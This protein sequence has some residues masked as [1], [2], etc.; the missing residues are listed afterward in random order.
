MDSKQYIFLDN[1][2]WVLTILVIVFHSSITAI[3]AEMNQIAWNLPNVAK[4]MQWQYQILDSFMSTYSSFFMCVF[5]FISAY[6]VSLSLARKGAAHFILDKLKRLGIPIL[7]T[8]FILFPILISIVFHFMPYNTTAL[9]I[10]H[11]SY[12]STLKHFLS[13]LL[14]TDNIDLGV[15]WFTWMLIV[16]STFFALSKKLYSASK[17]KAGDKRIPAIWLYLLS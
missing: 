1:L 17:L 15:T 7:M 13:P 14:R 4:S 11:P 5:F 12:M 9:G 3:S 10:T 6:F 8:L 16:F 2:K